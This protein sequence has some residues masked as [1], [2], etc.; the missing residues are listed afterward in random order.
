MTRGLWI[1]LAAV[2]AYWL[3]A[4][5]AWR[6][7]DGVMPINLW[8]NLKLAMQLCALGVALVVMRAAWPPGD[9]PL[10]LFATRLRQ[11][12]PVLLAGIAA[13]LISGLSSSA[14]ALT[15]SLI[16]HLTGFTSDRMLADL[17]AAIFGTDPWALFRTLPLME[18]YGIAY[19]YWMLVLL[20]TLIL[21]VFWWRAE[22]AYLAFIL[23]G[24]IGTA[25][26]YLMPSAGPI[27]YQRIGLGDRFAGLA[28]GSHEAFTRFADYLWAAQSAPADRVGLGIS[29][30]P[31]MHVGFAVWIA[32]AWGRRWA[33]LTV[34]YALLVYLASVASGW[35]Y[36]TD[37][38]AGAAVALL[39]WWLAGRLLAPPATA[40]P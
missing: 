20:F 29:A 13:M 28:E 12:I 19:V 26:Q 34:P 1:A 15:K 9:R 27:F 4:L 31:S 17:D 36:A 24:L 25:G 5:A 40:K 3:G 6:A 23:T 35:H 2:V 14:T 37:G 22:R 39:A 7:A 30:M 10:H 16:P 11:S 18:L 8:L 38:P 33:W 21:A 32:L